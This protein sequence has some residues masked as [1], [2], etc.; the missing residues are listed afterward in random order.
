MKMGRVS[1]LLL[2]LVAV[3]ALASGSSGA[4]TPSPPLLPDMRLVVPTDL[5]SIGLD[6]SGH[7]ELRFT[8]ITANLGPGLFEIDPAYSAKTG[9]AAFS[10]ALHRANGSVATRVQLATYGTW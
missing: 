9:V 1:R 7:R 4:A 8:H 5:I 10:Q 3:A 2:L 6:G